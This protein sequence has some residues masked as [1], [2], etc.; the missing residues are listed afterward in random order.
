MKSLHQP[1]PYP[2]TAKSAHAKF[3]EEGIVMKAWADAMGVSRFAVLDLLKGRG[4]ARRGISFRAAVALGRNPP[5]AKAVPHDKSTRHRGG[6]I[7]PVAGDRG[8][9][10]QR[11]IRSAS[12]KRRAGR[13]CADADHALR[14]LR[15]LA[16]SGWAAQDEDR[17]WRLTARP[18]QL[19]FS[20][21]AGLANA[22]SRVK[23]V[24]HNYTRQPV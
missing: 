22:H 6:P 24:G 19:I 15:T 8:T 14:D 3:Q 9:G 21:Q 10:R 18:L 5:P 13:R 4:K 17:H 7:S 2:Q 12:F 11:G 23:A 1:F 16:A 20:F